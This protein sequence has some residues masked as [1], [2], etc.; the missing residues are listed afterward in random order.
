MI[1]AYIDITAG[2]PDYVME[3]GRFEA[4]SKQLIEAL[5][6]VKNFSTLAVPSYIKIEKLDIG[7]NK[8]GVRAVWT[9]GNCSAL[10]DGGKETKKCPYCGGMFV[11][12]SKMQKADD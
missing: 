3:P 2:I 8:D 4:E 7:D 12:L 1:I 5:K 9:C 11:G 6:E 10:V